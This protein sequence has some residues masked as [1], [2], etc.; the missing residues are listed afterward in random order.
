MYLNESPYGGS[1]WGVK[2]AAKGYFGKD[3]KD[4]NLVESAILAGLP[5]SPSIYS[6]FIGKKDTWRNRTKDVLRRMREDGYINRDT[7][8]KAIADLERIHFSTPKL[9]ID[10]AHFVFYVKNQIE[11]EYGVAREFLLRE[12]VTEA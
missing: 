5:Q 8:K 7:E 10:G 3:V 9:T 12:R 2:T 6:P 1:F 4:L 11:E